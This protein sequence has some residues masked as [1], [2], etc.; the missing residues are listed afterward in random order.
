[1]ENKRWTLSKL[2]FS[3]NSCRELPVWVICE[4]LQ[5][6]TLWPSNFT[7]LAFALW[8]LS[9]PR[10]LS[11]LTAGQGQATLRAHASCLHL[12]R[13]LAP[14][15][16]RRYDSCIRYANYVLLWAG[17]QPPPSPQRHFLKTVAKED[18]QCTSPFQL[19]LLCLAGESCIAVQ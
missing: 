14:L 8:F 15:E 1:M 2:C 5:L 10:I 6:E 3:Y 11:W 16:E 19:Y 13:P 4:V 9:P 12:P 18:D 17:W 7:A